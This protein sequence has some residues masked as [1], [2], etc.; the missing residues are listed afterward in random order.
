MKKK[1]QKPSMKA[2][3]VKTTGILCGSGTVAA[4]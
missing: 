3:E 1:Y 4:A 2:V